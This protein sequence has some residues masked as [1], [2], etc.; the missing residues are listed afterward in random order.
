M[1][2]S[3]VV[4]C[5]FC[6]EKVLLKFQIGYF[7]IPFDFSC[8]KCGVSIY[9]IKKI[10]PNIFIINNAK[11]I[12]DKLENIKFCGY[13]STEFLNRKIFKYNS[14]E[15]MFKNG[16]SPFINTVM[17]FEEPKI[18]QN[19]MKK[20]SDYL[21]FKKI[22]LSKVKPLYELFFNDK[23]ELLTKPLLDF[24][25]SYIIKNNLDAE[26]ALHQIITIGMQH[27][28]PSNTLKNYTDIANKI[29]LGK[30][31]QETINFIKFFESKI[32][33]K[34]LSK[35][36]I[37]IYDRWVNDFEK[38]MSVIILSITDKTDEIDKET[39]GISTINFKD[40]ITFYADSY[41]LILEMIMLPIGLNNIKERKKYDCFPTESTINNFKT[42]FNKIKY[43]RVDALKENEEYSK[44]LNINRN[45]RNSI[46]HFDYQINNETQLI[47]FYDKYK[48]SE[49]NIE[50]FLF[51]FALLCYEN[52]KFII[53]LNELFYN[54]K[55]ISYITK[56]LKPSITPDFKYLNI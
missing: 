43:Q 51:D 45:V 55:K 40:M 15:D 37:E 39:Y 22:F 8:P 6:D 7:D 49:K 19:V 56:G 35:K 9:G 36:I 54:I 25:K 13:F 2:R 41:E 12:S 5:K 20:M 29:M 21:H 44:C 1:I 17:M 30:E 26:M 52:I 42:F 23:L 46:A 18:Y 27:I 14:L 33:I 31:I 24:S 47:T 53:Y 50:M 10:N 32:N 16:I 34:E 4:K 48:G 38:Y 3:G 28:M 11:E